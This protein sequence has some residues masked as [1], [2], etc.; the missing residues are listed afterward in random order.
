MRKTTNLIGLAIG[1]AVITV[2]LSTRAKADTS[3]WVLDRCN[4]ATLCTPGVIG[5]VGLATSGSGASEVIDVTVTAI[6]G[7]GLFGKNGAF[8]FNFAGND[9]G[10]A[11]TNAN[12]PFSFTGNSGQ[13]D[14]WGSFEFIVDGPTGSGATSP[15]TFTVTCAG[16]C[17]SVGQL[18]GELSSGGDGSTYFAAHM[19]NNSSGLTG[20][21]GVDPVES[22]VPEPSSLAL[23]G[24]GLL[25]LGG[26]LRRRLIG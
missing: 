6:S 16:G 18:A 22:P 21:A 25:G 19:R 15:L 10:V 17:T 26:A 5:T 12:S 14:G 24:S 8:G 2:S 20:F 11:I 23:L 9:A 3:S 4:I 7:Y 1:L 13:M